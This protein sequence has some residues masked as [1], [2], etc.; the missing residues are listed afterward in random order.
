VTGKRAR[1]KASVTA[2]AARSH[3]A[4]LDEDANDIDTT[5][6]FNRQG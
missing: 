3:R 6:W 1:A 5:D 4:E 2:G